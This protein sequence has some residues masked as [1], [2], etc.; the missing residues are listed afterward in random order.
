MCNR[1]CICLQWPV[2]VSSNPI[3]VCVI[4]LLA[5]D[6]QWASISWVM[7]FHWFQIVE[8]PV[9]DKVVGASINS[10][11]MDPDLQYTVALTDK[12]IVVI[13]KRAECWGTG[14]HQQL[15]LSSHETA[16]QYFCRAA[17]QSPFPSHLSM[18]SWTSFPGLWR[19]KEKKTVQSVL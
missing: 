19:K 11:A 4:K 9:E 6:K 1:M 14:R 7:S 15:G 17:F 10:V 5:D 2:G 8:W 13:L 16:S 3:G 18:C 12:N